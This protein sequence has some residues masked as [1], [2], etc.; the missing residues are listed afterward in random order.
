[1]P[2][3]YSLA[4]AKRFDFEP[5]GPE[6]RRIL[7][8][9]RMAFSLQNGD[10]QEISLQFDVAGLEAAIK[11]MPLKCQQRFAELVEAEKPASKAARPRRSS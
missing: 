8:S 2:I 5:G 1:L 10:L 11:Q 6:L 9:K 4:T 3:Q 7:A